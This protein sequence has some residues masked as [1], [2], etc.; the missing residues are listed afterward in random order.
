MGGLSRTVRRRVGVNYHYPPKTRLSFC[1]REFLFVSFPVARPHPPTP[2]R[3]QRASIPPLAFATRF[4]PSHPLP[5][6]PLFP[7][8]VHLKYEFDITFH[9]TAL[10]LSLFL[11]FDHPRECPLFHFLTPPSS[12]PSLSPSLSFFLS[13]R[14]SDHYWSPHNLIAGILLKVS[15]ARRLVYDFAN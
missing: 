1:S 6:L 5:P 4:S 10:S 2:S 8:T 15:T 12:D 9:P 11:S 7:I 13:S 3:R 14:L